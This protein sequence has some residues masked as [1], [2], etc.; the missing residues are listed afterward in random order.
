MTKIKNTSLILGIL[1]S[2]ALLAACTPASAPAE[3]QPTLDIA[4]LKAEIASTVI[5]EITQ[6]APAQAEAP[7][8]QPAADEP[9]QTPWI[10]TATPDPA[11]QETVQV[12]VP[13]LATATKKPASSGGAAWPTITPTYYTDV[14]RCSNLTPASYSVFSPGYDFDTVWTVENTGHR[15]WNGN[16]YY[17]LRRFDGTEFGPVFVG[18][19]NVGDTFS[20]T[21]DTVAPLNPGN[22]VNTLYLVNDDGVTFF[23]SAFVFTV[24]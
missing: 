5:A 19:L 8:E 2:L 13:V 17:K 9:T 6:Q 18:A 15:Q 22:Y 4:A 21:M 16:F 23:T 11:Q 10:I 14:A 3:S 1:L 20:A 7:A 12:A 24:K